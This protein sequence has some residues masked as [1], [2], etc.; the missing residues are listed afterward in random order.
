MF[1]ATML[2]Y[3]ALAGVPAHAYQVGQYNCNSGFSTC[4]S[5]TQATMSECMGECCEYGGCGSTNDPEEVCYDTVETTT[6]SDGTEIVNTDQTCGSINESLYNCA[7][8][9]YDNFE[10][11]TGNCLESYCTYVG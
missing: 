7:T 10:E 4:W 2:V 9:C 3:L 1:F 11:N 8:A 6:W 5:E